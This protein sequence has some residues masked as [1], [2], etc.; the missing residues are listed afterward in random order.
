MVKRISGWVIIVVIIMAFIS[1]VIY[2]ATD[3]RSL[4]I[5]ILSVSVS[6][7][8]VCLFRFAERLINSNDG[9]ENKKTPANL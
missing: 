3:L 1:A 2:I 4:L 9:K 5:L 6:I 8:V 7:V